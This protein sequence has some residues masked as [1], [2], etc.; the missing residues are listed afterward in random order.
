LVKRA[1]ELDQREGALANLAAGLHQREV[2]VAAREQ[3]VESVLGK[4][5]AE[6]RA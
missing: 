3:K 6:W 4:I 2:N 1:A 5:S